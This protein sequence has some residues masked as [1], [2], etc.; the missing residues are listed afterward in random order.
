MESMEI[1][2]PNWGFRVTA[3]GYCLVT[4]TVYCIVYIFLL[5]I[6]VVIVFVAVVIVFAL[7]SLYVVRPLLFV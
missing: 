5:I 4:V 3:Y 6:V 7:H 1:K 2:S